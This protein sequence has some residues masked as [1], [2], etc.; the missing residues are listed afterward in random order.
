LSAVTEE[1]EVKQYGTISLF[2]TLVQVAS[3]LISQNKILKHHIALYH[4]LIT[5]YCIHIDVS[6]INIL[7]FAGEVIIPSTCGVLS[8]GPLFLT[9]LFY[10]N[11]QDLMH[12]LRLHMVI[13]LLGYH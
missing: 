5:D 2:L 6:S 3:N 8:P 10:R 7:G 11:R 9:N 12:E 4:V 1:K 13:Q